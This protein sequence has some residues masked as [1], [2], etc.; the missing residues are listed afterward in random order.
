MI[1]AQEM[2]EDRIATLTRCHGFSR[3]GF[4]VR[5]LLNFEGAFL[6]FVV[7]IFKEVK[8]GK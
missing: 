7:Q 3:F 1:M 5:E 2:T 6:I 4:T 8:D